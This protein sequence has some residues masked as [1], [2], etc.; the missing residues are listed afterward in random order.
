[1]GISQHN[2]VAQGTYTQSYLFVKEKM[3]MHT[4]GTKQFP[5]RPRMR[6]FNVN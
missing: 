5:T 4:G 1:M 2:Y 3:K 6:N